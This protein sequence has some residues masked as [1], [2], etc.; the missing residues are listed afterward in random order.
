V[1][2]WQGLVC[3]WRTQIAY[4]VWIIWR[5]LTTLVG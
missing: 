1:V 5:T 3:S 4:A 2:V